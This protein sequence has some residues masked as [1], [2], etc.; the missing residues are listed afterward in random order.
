MYSFIRG[1]VDEIGADRAVLEAAGVGYELYCSAATL[2]TLAAGAQA[3]LYVHFH[4][5][6]DVVALYG[7]YDG[8]ERAMFRKLI[9]VTR[10]GPK[11]ALSVLSVLSVSDITGAILTEN[12][13]AFDRVPGMGRKT[14][15]RVLLELK[16]KVI[17]SAGEPGGIG[18]AEAPQI[19]MRTEAVAA[20]VSL[21]Y[22]GVT[23]GRAVAACGSCDR[24][25][26]LITQALK[27]LAGKGIG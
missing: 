2:K 24:I 21:G 26:D 27:S 3:K 13:A 19:D 15:A 22:D 17:A 20:L 1:V 10:V 9:S 6:Q 5:A 25:E 23:A 16:E 4:L 11:L 12:A 18:K 8:V 7:F 14:A